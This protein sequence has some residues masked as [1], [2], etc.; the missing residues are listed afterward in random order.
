MFSANVFRICETR[1]DL[2]IHKLKSYNLNNF[3]ASALKGVRLVNNYFFCAGWNQRLHVGEIRYHHGAEN[4]VGQKNL[5]VS[6]D[7]KFH[8][9][10][11]IDVADIGNLDVRQNI[12]SVDDSNKHV[13]DVLVAG[14]GIEFI[15]FKTNSE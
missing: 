9:M 4:K 11:F 13:F 10:A 2:E 15:K 5:D 1:R 7:L 3:C 12:N 14:Q 8:G 6:I